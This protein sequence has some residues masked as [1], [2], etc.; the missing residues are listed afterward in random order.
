ML[1]RVAGGRACLATHADAPAVLAGHA[2][3]SARATGQAEH[4]K[5]AALKVSAVGH[6][7][8]PGQRG[9]LACTN[10]YPKTAAASKICKH[11][12]CLQYAW[13]AHEERGDSSHRGNAEAVLLHVYSASQN[14]C[15][16]HLTQLNHRN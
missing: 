11:S 5:P 1:S 14:Q 8:W 10:L 6:C 4:L 12:C 2:G 7:C 9:L 3:R 16:L 15:M 13:P